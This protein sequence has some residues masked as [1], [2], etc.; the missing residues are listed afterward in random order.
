MT[1]L[2]NTLPVWSIRIS[3]FEFVCDLVLAC[4]LAIC[5]PPEYTNASKSP[6]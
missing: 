3:G 1:K 6:E 2:S 4:D 5:P